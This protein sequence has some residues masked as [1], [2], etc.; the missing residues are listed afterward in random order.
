MQF[1]MNAVD[2]LARL[3]SRLFLLIMAAAFAVV[4]LCFALLGLVWILLKALITGRKPVFVTSFMQFR[5]ASQQFRRGGWN[6]RQSDG[7]GFAP[8]GDVIEGQ[9]TEIRDDKALPHKEE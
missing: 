8:G 1:L 4:L 2:T 5:Q 7:D 3:L 6:S 9:A